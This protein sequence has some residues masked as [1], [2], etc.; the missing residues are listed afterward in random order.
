MLHLK[1]IYVSSKQVQT[2][3]IL[4]IYFH[5]YNIFI[6]SKTM[7]RLDTQ[8]IYYMHTYIII[9]LMKQMNNVQ[10]P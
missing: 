10:H 6:R 3:Q 4:N 2:C 5:N 7:Y 8:S 9:E 1:G